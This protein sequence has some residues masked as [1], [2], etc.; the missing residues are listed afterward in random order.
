MWA[1][2]M[3][4]GSCS[5]AAGRCESAEEHHIILR[6]PQSAW[7]SRLFVSRRGEKRKAGAYTHLVMRQDART[8][9]ESQ[10][11]FVET[12]PSA[13][14]GAFTV[15]IPTRILCRS[16]LE[17]RAGFRASVIVCAMPKRRL[18]MYSAQRG[19]GRLDKGISPFGHCR[20]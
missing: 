6:A 14:L 15:R 18:A 1:A 8:W 20:N 11:G 2:A 4:V 19:W 5:R 13:P 3:R 9:H 10:V 12:A 17:S 16:Q 7:T